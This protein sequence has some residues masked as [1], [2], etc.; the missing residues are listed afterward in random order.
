[1]QNFMVMFTFSIL[2][3]FLQVLSK[4]QFYFD[5]FPKKSPRS[6]VAELK[7]VAFLVLFGLTSVEVK[8]FFLLI[9]QMGMVGR[10]KCYVMH[11]QILYATETVYLYC[12][13]V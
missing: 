2:D 10:L 4:N 12:D 1:M 11:C 8:K 13:L 3:L 7:P 6:L 5:V 9:C